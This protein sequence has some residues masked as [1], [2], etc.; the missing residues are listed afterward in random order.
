[1]A[2]SATVLVLPLGGGSGG[3]V[4]PAGGLASILQMLF[5]P[6][7]VLYALVMSFFNTGPGRG[8]GDQRGGAAAG[9]RSGGSVRQQGNIGRL[10][11]GQDDDD[12]NNTWNGNS[13]QQM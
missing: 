1:M 10:R 5:T 7:T 8:S 12:E 13:T 11:N 4:L 2:P 9:Q 6:F 3:S